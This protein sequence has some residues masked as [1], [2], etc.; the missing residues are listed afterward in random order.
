MQ[1]YLLEIANYNFWAN[2]KLVN[3]LQ[4]YPD[5]LLTKEVISSFPSIGKTLFHIWGAQAIWQFRLIGQSPKAFPSQPHEKNITEAFNGLLNSSKDL[6]AWISDHLDEHSKLEK[7]I[8]YKTLNGKTYTQEA[9]EIL[10]HVMNHS[11]YHRGQIIM[12]AK[13]LGFRDLPSTDFIFYKREKS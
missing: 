4:N 10:I 8:S 13:Q 11:T 3:Y 5:E 12:M 9:H 7:S 1:S 2:Q 6:I